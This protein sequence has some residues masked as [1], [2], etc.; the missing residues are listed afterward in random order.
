MKTSRTR[1]TF[2]PPILESKTWAQNTALPGHL[3]LLDFSQA[4]PS[5]PPPAPMLQALSEAV[6]H[7]PNIHLYGSVLGTPELRAALAEKTGQ[8][9]NGKIKPDQIAITS[10]CNQAFAAVM[11]SLTTEGDEII[12]PTPWYFNHK[13][14]LDMTGVKA[15]A[16]NMGAGFLPDT[17]QARRLI[18]PRT[19]AI[20][21][22]SPSNPTGVEYPPSLI[23]A[24]YMLAREHGIPLILDETYRDFR[25][26]NGPAHEIFADPDW[27]DGFI[28]LYSF[29]KSFHLSGH[30]IGAIA[31]S[32]SFISE[33]AK[34][35][36]TVTI[37]PTGVGQAAAHWGLQHLD[38]W[39]EAERQKILARGETVQQVFKSLETHGWTLHSS[40]AYFA[41]VEH[42][43]AAN[44]ENAAQ[45][46]LSETG[47]LMLPASMFRPNGQDGSQTQF[48]IAFAN[49]GSDGI[50]EMGR[51]LVDFSF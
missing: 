44:F 38:D 13:M 48:R 2:F 3:P 1:S 45:F 40:G 14:W 30:R 39:L 32:T 24:F 31:A 15:V 17:D 46:V 27:P 16:L 26:S 47:I 8:L 11:A 29:S 42:P 10:G 33:V 23:K 6:L 18:G 34:F 5:S 50:K 51:R 49:L 37:C 43:E 19:K 28:H 21:L 36:D 22:I 12:L 35:L 25:I 41:Y 7:E 4:A 9:Y 20:V